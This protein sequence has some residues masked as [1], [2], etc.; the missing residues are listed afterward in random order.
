MRPAGLH[1]T[2][3]L[4]TMAEILQEDMAQDVTHPRKHHDPREGT[5]TRQPHL[6]VTAAVHQTGQCQ[7]AERAGRWRPQCSLLPAP[8]LKSVPHSHSEQ[9]RGGIQSGMLT[10]TSTPV[11]HFQGRSCMR[12]VTVRGWIMGHPMIARPAAAI[13][14]SRQT[15]GRAATMRAQARRATQA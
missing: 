13:P 9:A 6:L 15:I 12:Q 3:A 11:G 7:L 2:I 1:R 10:Q 4:A 5:K 14:G 8:L